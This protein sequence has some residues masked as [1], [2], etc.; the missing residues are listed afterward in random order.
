MQ[1]PG[2]LELNPKLW[3]QF[4]VTVSQGT[5]LIAKTPK[6]IKEIGVLCH[7]HFWEVLIKPFSF[8]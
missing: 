8:N 7:Y 3:S 6:V 1:V 2:F 4:W 5:D